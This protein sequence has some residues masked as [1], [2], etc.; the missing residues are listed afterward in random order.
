MA[1]VVSVNVVGFIN[2]VCDPGFTLLANQLKATDN[3]LKTVIPTVPEGTQLYLW[4]SVEQTFL[5]FTFLA[6]DWYDDITGELATATMAPGTAGFIQ[7]NGAQFTIT[8]VGEVPQNPDPMQTTLVPGLNMIASF[9]PV[10]KPL[11]DAVYSFP[12][13]NGMQYYKWDPTI[14]DY[15]TYSFLAGAWYSDITGEPETPQPAVAEGFFVSNPDTAPVTWTMS[16]S[17]AP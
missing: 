7:N 3:N 13:A 10:S 12:A 14:P 9:P 2:K 1:D 5:S 17:V 15:L 4:T 8:F 16:F 6:G 11:S